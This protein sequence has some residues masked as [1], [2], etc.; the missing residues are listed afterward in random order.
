[1]EVQAARHPSGSPSAAYPRW[2]ILE[3]Y[4]KRKN[5]SVFT[6][7]GDATTVAAARTSTGQPIR[8]FLLLQAPPA[9]SHVCFQLPEK[10]QSR[11]ALVVAAHG[12]SVLILV[13]AG[14]N[15]DRISDLFV[16]NAGDA[17]R[18]PSL[19]LLPPCFLTEEEKE[20]RPMFRSRAGPV[21]RFLD[22]SA[23]GLLR[24]GEDEIVVA[25]LSVVVSQDT[26]RQNVAEIVMLRSGE[27]STKRPLVCRHD[28]EDCDLPSSWK[29]DSVVA[30]GDRL[31]CWVDL[32]LGLMFCDV[33]EDSPRLRY[34]QLPLDHYFDR[35]PNRNVCVT[36]GGSTLKFVNIFPRCCC[37]SKDPIICHPSLHAYTIRSW[38][39]SMDDMAWV[40]DGMIDSTELCATLNGYR[41]LPLVKLDFPA[42][43]IDEP[44]VICFRMSENYYELDDN[45]MW[46]I[47]VDMKSKSLQSVSQYP[48]GAP[49]LLLGSTSSVSDHLNSYPI[50]SSIDDASNMQSRVLDQFKA[51][52]A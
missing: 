20:M 10:I 36:A 13:E 31:L 39:L 19:S 37:A 24:R 45:K 22:L 15:D 40:M 33:F 2:V 14:D 35:K 28:G 12:D 29:T 27:W 48:G 23:T 50:S 51:S 47:K 44:H 41:N 34:V 38:T 11:Y 25:E 8:A 9:T 7:D 6:V 30:V 42:V 3:F 21:H 32:W 52:E 49:W 4:C 17:P 26:R 16:Y 1:M 5:S 46:L 43:S 18:P